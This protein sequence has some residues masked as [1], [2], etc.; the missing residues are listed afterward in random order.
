MNKYNWIAIIII[1]ILI[2]LSLLTQ[3]SG[4]TDVQEYAGIAK[5]FSGQYK[6]DI[7]ASHSMLYSYMQAPLVYLFKSIFIMKIISLIFLILI[8]ISVYYISG[9]DKKAL[10][11][12]LFSPIIWYSSPWI[13]PISLASL[14][15]LWGYFF[16][17]KYEK[18]NKLVS[19]ICSGLLF[20]LAWAF[21]NTT[22]YILFFL[23]IVF[24]FNKKFSHL[25]L[26]IFS[27]VL[28]LMPLLLFD[29]IFYGLF[30]YSILRHFFGVIISSLYG[31]IYPGISRATSSFLPIIIFLLM[32][33]AFFHNLLRKDF[34]KENKKSIIF[35][36]LT[37]LFLL[38]NS[39]IRYILFFWPILILF[40]SKSLSEKQ[41]KIQLIIFA[42]ISLIVIAPYLVQIKYST[43][44]LEFSSIFSN[45]GNWKLIENENKLILQDLNQIEKEYPN[46]VF[47]VGNN[48][49]DYEILA[50]LYWGNKV[51][52]FVSI[53]DYQLN[54]QGKEILFFKTIESSPKI[55]DRRQIFISGGIKKSSIDNINYD[56]IKLAISLEKPLDLEGFEFIK[57]YNILYL[58]Q[59]L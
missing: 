35:L 9:K 13:T 16:L 33:P 32:M 53:Q 18:N 58:Y 8:I 31:G 46:Q 6:A 21:W 15:F 27:V 55:K 43:N 49:D 52:E 23:T 54:L 5:F 40:L 30:F 36:I 39:Q 20:G 4:H 14:F 44:T 2:L 41:F 11:L 56:S 51:K 7:R 42:V 25:V 48:P 29:Q 28:G 24:F 47:L 17:N 26:F 12:M 22:F 59:K 57:K 37:I 45:F 1:F 10:L 50:F 38:G 34:F 3:Y 19:L